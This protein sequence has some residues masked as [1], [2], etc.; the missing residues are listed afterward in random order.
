MGFWDGWIPRR[1]EKPPSYTKSCARADLLSCTSAL[2]T[3]GPDELSCQRC[4]SFP[5]QIAFTNGVTSSFSGYSANII[6]YQDVFQSVQLHQSD[7]F[8]S[9]ESV[10][11]VDA[12]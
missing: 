4:L 5:A 3:L 6:S 1:S 2:L 12:A 8:W 9:K 10:Q 7:D 11:G